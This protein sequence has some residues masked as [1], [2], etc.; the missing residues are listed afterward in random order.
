MLRVKAK[1]MNKSFKQ[2]GFTLLELLISML[3]VSIALLGFAGLQAFS[4]RTISS[5]QA[6]NTGK[7]AMQGFVTQLQTIQKFMPKMPW[8]GEISSLEITCDPKYKN[9]NSIIKSSEG[10]QNPVYLL[11]ND[12][13][14]VVTLNNIPGI[15]SSQL[16]ITFKRNKPFE[17]YYK[18]SAYV[19]LA[20]AP[21]KSEKAKNS[22]KDAVDF[23]SGEKVPTIDTYCPFVTTDENGNQT[24]KT[25]IDNRI[26][27]NVVCNETEV[28]L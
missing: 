10:T 4:A 25:N 5:T 17:G 11:V 8:S 27:D 13:C 7:E 16:K 28:M 20:Y 19:Q 23:S 26:K 1:T 22:T 18:Y 12:L 9:I 2:K 6:K 3:I 24:T 15:E 14:E 21:I